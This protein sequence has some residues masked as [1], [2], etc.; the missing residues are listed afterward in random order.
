M[1]KFCYKSVL[2]LLLFVVFS[3][4]RAQ[5]QP[6]GKFPNAV[7]YEIYVQS[8]ADSNGDGKGDIPGLTSNLYYLKELGVEVVWLMPVGPSRSYH[9]YDVRDYYNIDSAYGTLEDFKKFVEQAHARNIKVI[10]DLVINHS[11]RDHPW[12]QQALKDS[13]S[14]YW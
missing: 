8:F 6:V 10:I 12:F 11:G 7:S 2:F 5:N 1:R 4:T 9:K 13:T 14:P 3:S